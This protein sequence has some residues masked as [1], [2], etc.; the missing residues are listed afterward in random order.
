M[1][2]LVSTSA[3][4]LV[5]FKAS[6]VLAVAFGVTALLRRASAASR[7]LVWLAAFCGVAA[8]P[9]AAAVMPSLSIPFPMLAERT[10]APALAPVA[11]VDRVD[12]YSIDA[13]G[14]VAHAALVAPAGVSLTPTADRRVFAVSAGGQGAPPPA[15]V[16]RWPWTFRLFMLW[17]FGFVMVAVAFAVGVLRT[18]LVACAALPAGDLLAEEADALATSLGI[19]RAVRV[20]TWPGPAMPMTW[21][22]RRPVVL[23]PEDARAWPA[24]RRREVLTHELAHVRRGDWLARLLAA[25]V[26]ALHWFNP[27]VWLAARRLR[28]EQE[29][30]CDDA[31]LA[32]GVRPSDYAAHLLDVARGLRAPP[33]IAQAAVA[34]ARASQLSD[35]LLAVLDDSRSRVAAP[36]GARL[37]W[38]LAFA[39]AVPLGA[40]VPAAPAAQF[41]KPAKALRAATAASASAAPRAAVVA[42]AGPSASAAPAASAAPVAFAVPAPPDRCPEPPRRLGSTTSSSH[43]SSSDGDDGSPRQV[44]LSLREGNCLLEVR[45]VGNVRFSDDESG[46]ADVPRGAWV[47]VSEEG[48]DGPERRFDAAWRDGQLQRRWRVDGND[49]PESAE[50]RTWLASALRTAFVRTGFDAVPRAMRAYRAGGLDS[51]LRLAEVSGS[52]YARRQVLAAIIDSVRI[53]PAEAARIARQAESMSSDYERAELL[54]AVATRIRLDGAVQDAMAA[55]AATMSSDYE[56]RRVLSAALARDGL[57]AQAARS[58]LGT[59]AAM[60]SDYE[61]AELLISYLRKQTLGEDFRQAF[62]QAAGSIVSDY[63]RRRVLS[64]VIAKP[65][66]PASIIGDVCTLAERIRSDYER[67]ELLTEVIRRFG[68]NADARARIRRAAEGISSDYERDRVLAALGRITQ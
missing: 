19:G 20:V 29:L 68:S 39:L 14:G 52:D 35:R 7:H 21:G 57:S 41:P 40:A 55:A 64:A 15:A 49:V 10:P 30:A 44:T 11:H 8:L 34:M 59:A 33:G 62:F 60:S 5:A 61:K 32:S 65:D 45:I 48:G 26:C 24:A 25:L 6:L 46:I 67:A 50:L 31:V 38:F 47:R 51:A 27:L 36:G 22:A 3:L 28:D 12:V 9:L 43:S 1:I 13:G 42:G 54:I 53:P 2:P 4:L 63:E 37:A 17:V 16:D 23:L 56:R 58:L 66:A 18:H